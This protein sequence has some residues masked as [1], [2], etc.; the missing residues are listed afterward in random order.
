MRYHLFFILLALGNLAASAAEPAPRPLTSEEQT[1]ALEASASTGAA[2]YRHD[3]AAWL[4]T[5]AL[6]ALWGSDHDARVA[7]WITQ[8][9]ERGITVTFVDRTPEALYRIT[10][11]D[12]GVAG[13]V[14][15]L[16]T[17]ERLSA[18]EA[19]AAAA[20]TVAE[21]AGFEHCP[22]RYNTVTLPAAGDDGAWAVYLIPGTTRYEELPVGGAHRMIVKDGRLVSQRAYSRSCIVLQNDAKAVGLMITHLLDPTPTEIHVFWSLWAKKPLYVMTPPGDM[23]WNVDGGTIRVAKKD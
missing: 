13:P 8:E 12:A 1:T 17:P 10:V 7:G 18:Y 9:T 16:A 15:A 11:S 20:R 3:R 4:A 6:M 23:M 2:L 5:D 21:G 22:A 19:G 14:D